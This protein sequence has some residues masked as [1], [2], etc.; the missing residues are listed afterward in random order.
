MIFGK[1]ALSYTVGWVCV[2]NGV[3]H[4]LSRD[5]I[6]LL[7]MAP[8]VREKEGYGLVVANVWNSRL[9]QNAQW[10]FYAPEFTR[11]AATDN[12]KQQKP[13]D[14]TTFSSFSMQKRCRSHPHA[15]K[16]KWAR[17]WNDI[18]GAQ[19]KAVPRYEA[20][21]VKIKLTINRAANGYRGG[22]PAWQ[23]SAIY[24]SQETSDAALFQ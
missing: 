23:S 13:S 12:N 15:G 5:E 7:L 18:L 14:P 6:F 1:L 2:H 10:F 4:N 22:Q 11:S 3:L 19:K 20:S 17:K 21:I 9:C 24:I 16:N 8:V